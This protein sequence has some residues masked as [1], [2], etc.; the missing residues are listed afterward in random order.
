MDCKVGLVTDNS[1]F[2]FLCAE[3][4]IAAEVVEN[5]I[6]SSAKDMYPY[7]SKIIPE[8]Y[9]SEEKVKRLGGIIGSWDAAKL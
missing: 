8:W 1:C 4:A 6:R 3:I 5:T 7:A 2:F 9:A